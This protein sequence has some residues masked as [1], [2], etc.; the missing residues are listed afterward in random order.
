[1]VLVS[2]VGAGRTRARAGTAEYATEHAE[3]VVL[4]R[5]DTPALRMQLLNLT[6]LALITT[7][8]GGLKDFDG[9]P[10]SANGPRGLGL[11]LAPMNDLPLGVKRPLA[12][13]LFMPVTAAEYATYRTLEFEAR[14]AWYLA[15]APTFAAIAD[16]WP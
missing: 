2:T 7:S 8:P 9:F 3:F 14:Q 10:P 6:E 1:M 4:A 16:R 5:A 15:N 13:R 12:Y 11:I